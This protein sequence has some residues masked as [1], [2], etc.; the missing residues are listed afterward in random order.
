MNRSYCDRFVR[1]KKNS[2]E[3]ERARKELNFLF[4][5]VCGYRHLILKVSGVR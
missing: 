5:S 1:Q 4:T 3:F 2:K